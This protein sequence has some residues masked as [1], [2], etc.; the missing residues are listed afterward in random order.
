MLLAASPTYQ[1]IRGTL[2]TIFLVAVGIWLLIRTLKRSDDPSL[3]IFKW[4][5]TALVVGFMVWKVAPIVGAGG[6]GAA[7]GGIPLTVACGFMLAIIWRYNIASMIAKP[8]GSL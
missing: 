7:F 5:L 6:Y 8:F 3:L 2:I 4:F 1:I